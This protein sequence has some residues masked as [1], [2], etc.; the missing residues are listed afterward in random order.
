MK[1]EELDRIPG[2]Y[3]IRNLR[4]KKAVSAYLKKDTGLPEQK[5]NIEAI[6]KKGE[7][8]HKYDPKS[9][10]LEDYLFMQR[11]S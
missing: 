7:S 1:D 9:I 4:D 3:T 10:H 11:Q 2:D 5:K 8:L 6:R